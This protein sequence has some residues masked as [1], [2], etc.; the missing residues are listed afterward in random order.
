MIFQTHLHILDHVSY[1]TG[2]FFDCFVTLVHLMDE[3]LLLRSRD[4]EKFCS[5]WYQHHGQNYIC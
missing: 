5:I 2:E 4:I 3:I 1:D